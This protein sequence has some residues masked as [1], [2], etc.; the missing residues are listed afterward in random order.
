MGNLCAK[1]QINICKVC[2]NK[3]TDINS[4]ICDVCNHNIELD[5]RKIINNE[6]ISLSSSEYD[7][8]D[9]DENES[10]IINTNN[11]NNIYV[12]D[13]NYKSNTINQNEITFDKKYIKCNKII[14]NINQKISIGLK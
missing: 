10:D 13:D 1:S 6:L 12:L 9:L 7:S 14:L 3:I 8:S 11:E 4:T 5:K 2:N